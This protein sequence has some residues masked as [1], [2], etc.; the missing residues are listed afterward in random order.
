MGKIKKKALLITT[1]MCFFFKPAQCIFFYSYRSNTG[2]GIADTFEVL[3][4][5]EC[6][7][8]IGMRSLCAVVSIV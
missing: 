7:F 5:V 8:H 1:R 2:S 4:P 3:P 6:V